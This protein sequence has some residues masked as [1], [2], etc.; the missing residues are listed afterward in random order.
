MES[1]TQVRQPHDPVKSGRQ[2]QHEPLWRLYR[3]DGRLS[4]FALADAL[5]DLRASRLGA[6]R[7]R[8]PT[9]QIPKPASG[10]AELSD[11]QSNA[12]SQVPAPSAIPGAKRGVPQPG[13][14]MPGVL[15]GK[16]VRDY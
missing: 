12:R 10:L 9:T 2:T 6:S 16:E 13:E 5:Q 15:K 1:E 14:S 4:L 3:K 8:P 11:S 7:L